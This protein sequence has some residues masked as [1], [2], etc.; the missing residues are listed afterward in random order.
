[1]SAMIGGMEVESPQPSRV[2]RLIQERGLFA[3]TIILAACSFV[4]CVLLALALRGNIRGVGPPGVCLT[5][6]C[7][8]AAT[9]VLQKMDLEKDPCD[10]FFSFSCGGWNRANPIPDDHSWFGTYPM[11]VQNVNNMLH[12]LLEHPVNKSGDIEAVIKAKIFYN[13]CMN[14]SAIQT[15]DSAPL[16]NMLSESH[17]RWPVLGEPGPIQDF[18]LLELLSTLRRRFLSSIIISFYLGI[19]DK[20]S[21]AYILKVDQGFV[22]LERDEY[23]TNTTEAIRH[24][25]SLLDLMV[26]VAVMLGAEREQAEDDMDDVLHLERQIAAILIPQESRTSESIYNRHTLAELKEMTPQFDWLAYAWKSINLDE[27]PEVGAIGPNETMIVMAP[28]YLI[29]L[30]QLLN[31]T[32]S[33]V[34][35]N[36]L[37]WRLIAYSLNRLSP[38]FSYRWLDFK[39]EVFGTRS[40]PSRWEHCVIMTKTMVSMPTGRLFIDEHFQEDKLEMM[41]ELVE[42]IRW[43]FVDMLELENDW[44][45]SDTKQ[46]AAEKA[47]AVMAKIGYPSIFRNDTYLNEDIEALL[48]TNGDY[49]GNILQC[50]EH[51]SQQNFKWLRKPVVKTWWS[52]NPTIVN[53][54]YSSSTN[55]IRFPAGELQ[56]PFFWGK[57]Y[58]LSLSYGAIG[59]IVGHELTH[60]FDNNGRKYNKDGNLNQ[61]WSNTSITAFREKAE[62]MV[63]QYNEYHWHTAG[64]DLRGNKTIG[65]NIADNGGLRESFRAY[66]RWVREERGGRE[67]DPLPG[68]PF[69]H[70]QLFFI[71]YAHVRCSSHREGSARYQILGGVHSP[72][73][74]RV[75]GGMSNFEEFAKAFGCAAGTTMN[76]G[77]RSCRIW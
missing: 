26:D 59:V 8:E 4:L 2:R 75:I 25:K 44:M 41:Q 74:Y 20:N 40:L 70:N 31:N 50:L 73:K 48:F 23:I 51:K 67:E 1:M 12:V 35:A 63:E 43:A 24:I 27:N 33:R 37:V 10:D 39:Q 66:R 47:Q 53:A 30:F 60:A 68:L 54:F 22:F 56:K 62:C 3:V 58:P 49:F 17:L 21:S 34:V 57:E 72:P 55:Q 11:L 77:S 9:T 15:L 6:A 46:R 76:R 69:T 36:Y 61:W 64:M 42:G 28:E 19:D 13:S 7:V 16:L 32:D 29:S 45:D 18:D 14:N 71:S 65:E 52:T 5:A 38:R